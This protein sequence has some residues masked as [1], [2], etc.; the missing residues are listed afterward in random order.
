L[1]HNN[2]IGIYSGKKESLKD[3]CVGKTLRREGLYEEEE[4]REA[5]E[6]RK[7]IA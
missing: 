7:E 1:I 5:G 3:R 6:G 2:I 4:R